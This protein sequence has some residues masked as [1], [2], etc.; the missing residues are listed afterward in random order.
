MADLKT[1]RETAKQIVRFYFRDDKDNP[2]ELSDGQ[3]DIFNSIFLKE[4]SRNQ[5]IAPTQYGKSSTVAMA[6][7]L[8]SQAF[9]E[10]WTIVTGEQKKS[11]VIMEKVIQHLFNHKNLYCELEIDT[12][13]PLEKIKRERSKKRINWKCGGGLR[14]ITADAKNRHRVKESLSG[15][16]SPNIIED[17]ASLIPDNLQS[18]ILRMLGGHQG[19]FLLKIGNPYTRG[20][21]F[22]TWNSEKYKKIFID[23]NIALKEGRYTPEFIEEMRKEAF[24]DIL[25]ECKFPAEEELDIDGYRRLISDIEISNLKTGGN[26]SGILKLGFDVGEGGD[27]NVGVL[28]SD[29]FAQIVF[30]SKV[31]DL[32]AT[33]GEIS[34]IIKDY[35]IDAENCFVDDTGIGAGVVDRLHELGHNVRGIKWAEKPNDD[36][37]LNKKAENFWDL[38]NWIKEGGKL[39]IK[40]EWNELAEIK[41]KEDSS[42][43]VKIKSK[44]E[45]RKEGKESPNCF[46]AGTMIL[47]ETGEIPIEQIRIGDFVITPKGKRKVIAVHKNSSNNLK[48]IKFRNG[49]EITGTKD[50]EIVTYDGYTIFDNVYKN[51]IVLPYNNKFKIIWNKVNALFLRGKSFGF[52]SMA[53]TIAEISTMEQERREGKRSYYTTIFGNVKQKGKFLA[54]I[55]YIILTIILL[56]MFLK[57][58]HLLKFQNIRGII[59]KKNSKMLNLLKKIKEIC[60][61]LFKK[62]KNGINLKQ[63]VNGIKNT[64]ENVG[65]KKKEQQERL[66]INAYFVVNYLKHISKVLNFV[67]QNAK[68]IMG[69]NQVGIKLLNELANFAEK[70]LW[71]IDIE[72]TG[73]VVEGVQK[74][75]GGKTE[76]YNITLENENVFYA[77]G[78]LVFNCA[79]ALALSFNMSES[80]GIRFL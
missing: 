15:L 12:K 23:Y 13:E 27:A 73:F 70:N 32:M 47:T 62:Q 22:K 79:D 17:E 59:K 9:A 49:T 35:K 7:I 54:D 74:H 26:H 6:L 28:R 65:Q 51:M 8:R 72:K 76:V 56:I 37:F 48:T 24:F 25:Y 44:E 36:A 68:G 63:E 43:K 16:G 29:K 53:T 42:G 11:D 33:V 77:N 46:I 5:I 40:D 45:M 80:V 78:V 41:Y 58:S 75:T 69:I 67:Q 30:L 66:K 1:K 52:K 21:F 64:V 57:I 50:H 18:M 39:E 19:G 3:A 38:R 20:H 55:V 2:F 60:K 10:E 71:Q 61:K 4:N 14:A 34:R 31:S